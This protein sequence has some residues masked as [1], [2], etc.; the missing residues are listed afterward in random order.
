MH[1]K[2]IM[3]KTYTRENLLYPSGLSLSKSTTLD[4]RFPSTHHFVH[5]IYK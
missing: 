5:N 2:P 3:Y 4:E 1:D